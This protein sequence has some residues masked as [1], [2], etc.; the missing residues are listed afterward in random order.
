MTREWQPKVTVI[1]ESQNLN[2]LEITALFGKLN[3]HENKIL[4]LKASDEDI[5]KKEKMS[6]TAKASSSK[7]KHLVEEDNDINE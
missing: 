4:R 2:T 3:E 7:A 5:N 6:F 1:K